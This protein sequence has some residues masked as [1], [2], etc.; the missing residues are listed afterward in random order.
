MRCKLILVLGA[1]LIMPGCGDRERTLTFAQV[2]VLGIQTS[3]GAGSPQP[4]ELT[5]GYKGVNYANV[6]T[7]VRARDESGVERDIVLT[8]KGPGGRED[9]LSVYGHFKAQA[10]AAPTASLGKFF[11]T[12][13]AAQVLADKTGQGIN[14]LALRDAFVSQ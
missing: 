1:T 13:V 6:P 12:G 9:A 11:A 3:A 5:L 10:G 4:V 14:A 8:S 7:V 2:E